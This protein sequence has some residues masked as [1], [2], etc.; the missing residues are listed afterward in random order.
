[1]KETSIGPYSYPSRHL[2]ARALK[3]EDVFSTTEKTLNE[4]EESYLFI[5][6]GHY[7]ELKKLL[8]EF[9]EY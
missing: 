2:N 9:S 6:E 3:S 1:M 7:Q 5:E 8:Q 4:V